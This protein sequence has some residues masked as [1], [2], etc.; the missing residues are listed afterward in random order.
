MG[1]HLEPR[2]P[3]LRL[4]PRTGAAPN[5]T[6]TPADRAWP[7]RAPGS[8]SHTDTGTTSVRRVGSSL[9]TTTSSRSIRVPESKIFSSGAA[10]SRPHN[11]TRFTS[12]A[13]A[14]FVRFGGCH[15]VAIAEHHAG[16]AERKGVG[17]QGRRRGHGA[18]RRPAAARPLREVTGVVGI[19][20]TERPPRARDAQR[21]PKHSCNCVLQPWWEVP[22]SLIAGT[23]HD[24]APTAELCLI[25]RSGGGRSW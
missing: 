9:F 17:P 11:T 8:G 3:A 13:T 10:A 25:G 16:R 19:Q 18:Q 15:S 21:H 1:D 22:R 7:P 12:M 4:C 24:V 5:H 23:C 2:P 6:P 14:P 20:A